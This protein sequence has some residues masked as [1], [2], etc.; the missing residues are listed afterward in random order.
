MKLLICRDGETE[1]ETVR[2]MNVKSEL[3]GALA[4]I[5]FLASGD[6]AVLKLETPAEVARLI[7]E[8]QP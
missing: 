2:I 5:L 3:H 4:L 6:T 8:L 1:S 7:D